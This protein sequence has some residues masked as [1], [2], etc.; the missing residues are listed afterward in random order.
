MFVLDGDDL[1]DE[2]SGVGGLTGAFRRVGLRCS[3]VH[4]PGLHVGAHGIVFEIE[5]VGYRAG[6]AVV[7]RGGFGG[8]D[9]GF[10]L[11]PQAGHERLRGGGENNLL[12]KAAHRLGLNVV[13][14]IVEKDQSQSETFF[15]HRIGRKHEPKA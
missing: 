6:H 2:G 4:H 5:C 14:G 1:V 10:S 12:Q 11:V 7:E 9:I 15:A 8:A 13:A 3:E